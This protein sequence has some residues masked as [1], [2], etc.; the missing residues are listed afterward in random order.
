MKITFINRMLGIKFGGGENLDLNFALELSKR[1]HEVKIISGR[2]NKI[3]PPIIPNLG[4]VELIYIDTIYLRKYAYRFENYKYLTYLSAF[5]FEID[6]YF[7]GLKI[8]K[9]LKN[10]N[11]YSDVYHLGGLTRLAKKIK[12]LTNSKVVIH[13]VGKPGKSKLKFLEDYD[14]N[15]AGGDVF[16]FIHKRKIPN[17][18]FINIGVDTLKFSPNH[19]AKKSNVISFLSLGRLVHVKNIPL[20]LNAFHLASKEVNNI[21]LTICGS[22][23]KEIVN[24][25]KEFEKINKRIKYLGE[26]KREKVHLLY[27][28]NNVFLISSFYDNY[29]NT[30][31]E[32]LSSGLPVIGTNVGGIP[33]Q[34][35]NG[36]NGIL[37]KSNNVIEF[38][39]AIIKIAS[40]Q[41]LLNKMSI[42][43]RKTI[44]TKHSWDKRAIELEK[45]LME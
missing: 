13:W 5:F 14:L 38:K 12:I 34:I 22:G 27:K 25:V 8:A 23:E 29:P 16:K 39:N 41:E 33:N 24:Q 15:L 3:K 20:L 44:I 28:K 31:L 42:Q 30:V 21:F 37:T 11:F 40:S 9:Y 17:L 10:Q 4:N 45:I 32:A 35:T 19:K 7:F 2:N 1:G 18:K 43:A 6:K 36:L 26:V